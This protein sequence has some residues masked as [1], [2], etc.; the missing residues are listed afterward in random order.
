MKLENFKTIINNLQ[1]IY[2]KIEKV[3]DF[4]VN[5]ICEGKNNIMIHLQ[6][7][8]IAAF[9]DHYNKEG[10]DWIIWFIYETDFQ[11]NGVLTVYNDKPIYYDIDSLHKYIEEHCKNKQ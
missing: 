6:D 2:D 5:C 10:V 3:V 1:S 9:S 4:G 7:I 11:E 8:V